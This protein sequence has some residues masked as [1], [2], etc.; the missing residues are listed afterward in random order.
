MS[1]PEEEEDFAALLREYEG[2]APA[3]RRRGPKVGDVVTGP[4]VSIGHDAV[5]IELGAK[6]EAMLE[7]SQV[8]DAD[9]NVTVRVGDQ[10]EA[11]VV[12]N[13]GGTVILRR[14]MGHGPDA[15]AELVQAH[16]HG[17]PVSGQVTGVIKGGV[18]VQ[19]AGH[20]AFCPISQ[21]DDRFVEDAETF[22]GRRLEFRITRLEPGRG[23]N[24][25]LVVSRRALL[26][27]EA[28][29]RAEETRTRLE[30]GAV[31]PGT[32]ASIKPYGAFVDI[33]GIQGMLHISELGHTRV[34]NPADVLSEGQRIEVQVIKIEK[35]GDPKRPE[36]IGLSLK[37]LERDPWDDVATRFAEGAHIRGT[38]SRL[39]QFG[40][41][42][43]L[44]PGIEGL[45]HISELGTERRISHPREVVNIGDR[46]E[47]K[48]LAIDHERHR[49]SLSLAAAQKDAAAAAEAEQ[50]ATYRPVA[51]ALGTFG[52]LLQKSMK[53]K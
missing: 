41:F 17:M 42:V 37:S 5:F 24:L 52:D 26:E 50:V 13:K 20:R 9:G 22:V 16:E 53:K 15:H 49:I 3:G 2:N 7:L 8:T 31:F 33:G 10:V 27:E 45:I 39:Q 44:A 4:V 21:L 23:S 48:V 43:E 11:R 40:A 12:E 30:I 1:E 34:D 28:K 38:I 29:A 18:E 35:T 6:S 25:N 14:S 47:V 46:V 51:P 36:K 19:I 32:V